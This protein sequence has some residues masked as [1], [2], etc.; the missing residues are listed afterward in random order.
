MAIINQETQSQFASKNNKGGISTNIKNNTNY[1]N[2]L[3]STSGQGKVIA[4]VNPLDSSNLSPKPGAS[5]QE[6]YIK[7]SFE[8]SLK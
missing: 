6:S 7:K 3:V 1:D 8:R 2:T 4:Q 5:T